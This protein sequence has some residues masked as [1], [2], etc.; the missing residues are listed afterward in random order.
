MDAIAQL[1]TLD[2]GTI[3][4]VHLKEPARAGLYY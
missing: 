4:E 3:L 2:I 1:A